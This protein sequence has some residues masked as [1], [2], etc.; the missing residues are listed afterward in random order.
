ME[1]AQKM[2]DDNIKWRK[3]VDADTK[4]VKDY[5]EFLKLGVNSYF[6]RKVIYF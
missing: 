1:K 5:P 6:Y 4:K 3:E 2:F